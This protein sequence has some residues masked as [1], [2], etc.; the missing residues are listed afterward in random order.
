MN[1]QLTLNTRFVHEVCETLV[2]LSYQTVT[3]VSLK[4]D[5][6]ISY[7]SRRLVKQSETPQKD[8][9]FFRKRASRSN[10][11]QC[12]WQLGFPATGTHNAEPCHRHDPVGN[13]NGAACACAH[14]CPCAHA[15]TCSHM[16][17]RAF[18]AR[19]HG[20]SHARR[21]HEIAC[22]YRSIIHIVTILTLESN[23]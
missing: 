5:I 7:I 2:S 8:L 14:A 9:Y 19:V 12:P 11:L 16:Q 18:M 15:A 1:C 21:S 3:F 20:M 13:T 23:A 6:Y 22:A 4:Y 10:S 17:T